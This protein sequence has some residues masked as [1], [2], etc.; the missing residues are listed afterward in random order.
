M[1]TNLFEE[2]CDDFFPVFKKIPDTEKYAITIG[3][4]HGKGISDSNSDYDFRIYYEKPVIPEKR[5][6]IS[7][8]ISQLV[9]KWREK[10]I[11][12]DYVWARTIDE[13]NQ[14]IDSAMAGNYELVNKEWTV[15]GYNVLT[16]IYSQKIIEDP[17]GIAKTWKDRLS[18]YPV[19][20]KES[21]IKKYSS[22]LK[23]WTNDYHYLNKVKREDV[24]FLASITSR[25]INDI[26]QLIYALNEFYYPGDGMNL[27]YTKQFGKKPDNF[28]ERTVK[29]LYPGPSDDVFQKQ[30][31][32]LKKLINDTLLLIQ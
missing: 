13:I 11:E 26:V 10:K 19:K 14:Y 7:E 15:W 9:N 5:K 2:I 1:K 31:D 24:T 3:G 8:E 32:E 6:P 25:L 4:S 27:K 21:I 18:V 17:F 16:D 30:Y 23:Y 28:E 12:V 29:I 22:S 20:L